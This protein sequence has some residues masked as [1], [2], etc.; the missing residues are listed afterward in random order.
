[1]IIHTIILV[2]QIP[3]LAL[4]LQHRVACVDALMPFLLIINIA[5][6]KAEVNG[7][8]EVAPTIVII[9]VVSMHKVPASHPPSSILGLVWVVRLGY[10]AV[11]EDESRRRPELDLLCLAVER[12]SPSTVDCDSSRHNVTEVQDVELDSIVYTSIETCICV[13]G[14]RAEAAVPCEI[15]SHS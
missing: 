11:H 3:G 8:S 10:E 14:V 1:M 4:C 6:V 9:G 12:S 7:C 2:L 15:R 5:V 13:V